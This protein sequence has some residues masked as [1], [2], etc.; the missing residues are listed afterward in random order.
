[1]P[2]GSV[3]GIGRNFAQQKASGSPSAEFTTVDP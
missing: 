3:R 2:P 1:L